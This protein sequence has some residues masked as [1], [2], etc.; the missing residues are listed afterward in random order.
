MT[1]CTLVKTSYYSIE[2]KDVFN[3][4]RSNLFIK[5]LD[6]Y[7]WR[8]IQSCIVRV[9]NVFKHKVS[10]WSKLYNTF[11]KKK[12]F[13]HYTWFKSTSEYWSWFEIKPTLP[14]KKKSCIIHERYIMLLYQNGKKR[15]FSD[16]HNLHVNAFTPCIIVCREREREERVL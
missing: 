11:L 10:F 13:Y 3:V 1:L 5:G 15:A 9:L 6:Q 14:K 2:G 12:L 16:A 4:P 7:L 8:L